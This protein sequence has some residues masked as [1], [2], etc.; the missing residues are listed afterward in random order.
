MQ[1]P[2]RGRVARLA[3]RAALPSIALAF[4]LTTTADAAPPTSATPQRGGDVEKRVDGIL[5][6]MTL[7]EKL[8]YLGGFDGFYIRANPRLHLPALRMAD[9]P[10]GIRNFGPSTGYAG[11]H[12]A[13]GFV[14]TPTSPAA[15]ARCSAATPARAACTSCLAPR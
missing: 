6:R 2:S 5:E 13:G 7:D 12:R 11:R 3:G 14:R 15:S 1:H 10:L 8:D 9:G 4:T